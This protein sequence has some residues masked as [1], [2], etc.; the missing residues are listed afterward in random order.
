MVFMQS[1]APETLVLDEDGRVPPRRHPVRS[2]EKLFQSVDPVDSSLVRDVLCASPAWL[3]QTLD[4]I[5]D[6]LPTSPLGYRFS[7][8]EFMSVA[9]GRAGMLPPRFWDRIWKIGKYGGAVGV[10]GRRPWYRPLPPYLYRCYP[11]S[12]S[13]SFWPMGWSAPRQRLVD[14]Y[15]APGLVRP[16]P[17]SFDAAMN[18]VCNGLAGWHGSLEIRHAGVL[19]AVLQGTS[20]A[21][22]FFRFCR[23]VLHDALSKV[24]VGEKGCLRPFAMVDPSWGASVGTWRFFATGVEHEALQEAWAEA[25]RRIARKTAHERIRIPR[26]LP[27]R[28]GSAG[29][30]ILL[31]D[32]RAGYGR[33]GAGQLDVTTIPLRPSDD[34]RSLQRR[35]D[36]ERTRHRRG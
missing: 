28:P 14:W 8:A 30:R 2:G 20:V 34:E 25:G 31:R 16:W 13:P 5:L 27:G 29:Q 4:E 32:I 35:L 12:A 6:G 11:R 3:E 10:L 26:D 18:D 24:T 33:H 22:A 7:N 23:F 17:E 36:W 9:M 21:R 1:L 15:V 19:A